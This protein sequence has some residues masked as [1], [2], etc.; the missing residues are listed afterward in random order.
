MLA[1]VILAGALLN[2]NPQTT[3]E[4]MQQ[5]NDTAEESR[6]MTDHYLDEHKRDE[7]INALHDIEDAIIFD[8]LREGDD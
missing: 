5:L 7:E 1:G 8:S 4:A 2:M 3:N 6:R